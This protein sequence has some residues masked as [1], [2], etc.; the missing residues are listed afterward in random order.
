MKHF[1]HF[2]SLK[3]VDFFSN[4]INELS[5]NPDFFFHFIILK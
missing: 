4:F 5:N 1:F 2:I 3:Y